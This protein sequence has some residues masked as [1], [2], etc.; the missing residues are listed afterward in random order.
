MQPDIPPPAPARRSRKTPRRRSG[1]ARIRVTLLGT[2][3]VSQNGAD[4][5]L[6]G[7]SRRLLALLAF[8]PRGISRTRAAEL[9]YPESPPLTAAS[10]L[11]SA[12]AQLRAAV[13]GAVEADGVQ[14]RLGGGITVDARELDTLAGDILDGSGAQGAGI[15]LSRL[16]AEVLPGWHDDWVE[17][18]RARMRGRCLHAIEHVAAH[19]T[20]EARFERAIATIHLA[21]GGEGLRESAMTV[22]I[23]AHLAEGNKIEAVT[24]YLDYRK[25]LAA[26]LGVEPSRH[27]RELMARLL[28]E[29]KG[30]AE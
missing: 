21:L 22:L 26:A 6:R 4:A 13:P 7:G 17:L 3:A 1:A 27:L 28:D 10:S 20:A 19:L 12:L 23:E 18:E 16:T 30:G 5:R 9:L 29:G 24:P 15:N 25:R 11:R 8:S 2:F 14:L